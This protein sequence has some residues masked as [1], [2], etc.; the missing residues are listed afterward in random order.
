M[1]FLSN[2]IWVRIFWGHPVFA[3]SFSYAFFCLFFSF[4]Y[5]W[6]VSLPQSVLYDVLLVNT[7][8]VHALEIPSP[9]GP[10]SDDC[11]QTWPEW[12]KR[13]RWIRH[14]RKAL[15]NPWFRKQG[16]TL[17]N[18]IQWC[19]K[20]FAQKICHYNSHIFVQMIRLVFAFYFT[21]CYKSRIHY[22]NLECRNK[23]FCMFNRNQ[24]F[25]WNSFTQ[26]Y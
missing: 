22:R 23:T 5:S 20:I 15:T 26:N 21:S 25:R 1:G 4:M 6:L 18:F 7:L 19:Q 16:A 3:V 8:R 12:S 2:K 11:N 24:N 13:M 14:L 10:H 9:Y 17:V